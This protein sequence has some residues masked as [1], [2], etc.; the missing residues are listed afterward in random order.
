MIP[1]KYLPKLSEI[2][3]ILCDNGFSIANCAMYELTRSDCNELTDILGFGVEDICCIGP[4][5]AFVV[6]GN[7]AFDR[8]NQLVAGEI[9]SACKFNEFKL[10]KYF[11][12]ILNI[13]RYF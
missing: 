7:N 8:L 13:F 5:V 12:L 10:K 1:T 3:K 11:F 2:F 4:L 6:T 9:Y